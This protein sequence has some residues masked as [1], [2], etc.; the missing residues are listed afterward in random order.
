VNTPVDVVGRVAAL[1]RAVSA[2][3]PHGASTSDV[4]RT[5]G[6]ARPTTHRLLSSLAE[7]GLA[8]RDPDGRWV[9]GPELY[10]L[11]A[12][13]ASRYDVTELARPVVHRL[14][15]ATGESAFF[16]ARR[17]EE[18]VCLVRE[19]GSFPIRSHVLHEGIRFPLGVASAGLVIL[20]YLEDAEVGRYLDRAGL[21][22]AYGA[23]HDAD[24]LR[25]R[26]A[27][28]RRAGWALNPGLI[29][30]GSWGMAAA[31]FDADERPQWA[32]SLTG[33]QQRFTAARQRELGPLLLREAHELSRTLQRH[34]AAPGAV[35]RA[36]PRGAGGTGPRAPRRTP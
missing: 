33:I 10:I 2:A 18:T 22:A 34:S 8:E 6:L 36:A 4:A 1:L 26:I 21:A 7:T 25:T 32:L 35:S 28:T 19:D 24:A 17:G 23:A 15:A 29:V 30:E 27:R 5:A 13:S 9:L 11:G 16:S 3:E 12:A 31:V 14:S 20:A